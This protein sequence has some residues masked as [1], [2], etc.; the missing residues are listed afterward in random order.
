[1]IVSFRCR[2][3]QILFETEQSRRWSGIISVAFRKLAYLD[4]ASTLNDLRQPPGNR[5]EALKGDL[6]EFHSIRI[7]GQ[8]RVIFEW[9]NGGA[10]NVAIVDYH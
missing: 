9:K 3:T 2:D 10:H 1:M 8:W 4:A 7:N 6:A 5:L